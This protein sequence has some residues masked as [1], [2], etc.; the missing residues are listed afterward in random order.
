MPGAWRKNARHAGLDPRGSAARTP[1]RHG[2]AP[3]PLPLRLLRDPRRGP[4]RSAAAARSATGGSRCS[5]SASLGFAVADRFMRQQRPPGALGRR[6]LGGAAGPARAPRSWSPAA[7]P[8]R[9]WSGSPCRPSPSASASS[10]AGMVAGTVYVL[11]MFLAA[12]VVPDPH[13]AWEQRQLLIADRRPDRQHRDPLRRPGRVRPRPPPPL[14]PRPAHRPLQPQR[15]RAAPRRARRA[16]LRPGRGPLARLPALRPRPLQAGQRPVRPRRRR[17]GPPGRRLHDAGGPAGRRLD[18]PR[19]RRGDPG[20]AARRRPR[21]RAG[22]RRAPAG[23]GA[24]APPGRRPGLAQHRRRRR[25]ARTSSTPRTCSP[26]PTRRST[27]PRPA[28]ATSS[29]STAESRA[30]G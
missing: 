26:A 29:S 21:G 5:S 12:A 9:S 3:A 4:R 27:R 2:G 23:R 17:R 11:A 13:A 7:P 14:D 10:R 28:A 15:A 30:S 24:R 1:A 6:R 16:A 20:D 25:R 18:L 19:R 8:A 22:D